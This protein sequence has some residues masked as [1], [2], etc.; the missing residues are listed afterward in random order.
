MTAPAPIDVR[1]VLERALDESTVA[2]ARDAADIFRRLRSGQD[3][4][5]PTMA[6]VRDRYAR[7]KRDIAVAKAL[8]AEIDGRPGGAP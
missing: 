5:S 1:E 7:H 8:L 2:A 4:S 6:V 3:W